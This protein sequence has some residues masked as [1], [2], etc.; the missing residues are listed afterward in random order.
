MPKPWSK[1][2]IAPITS[3]T[4]SAKEQFS[5]WQILSQTLSAIHRKR[6]E[7]TTKGPLDIRYNFMQDDI[8]SERTIS[9]RTIFT[10]VWKFGVWRWRQSRCIGE[11][12][13]G[14]CITIKIILSITLSAE[15][16]FSDQK[17]L[18]QISGAITPAPEEET[19]ECQG[20]RTLFTK[21]GYHHIWKK[22]A[23]EDLDD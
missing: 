19:T 7:K 21:K 20:N 12:Q 17:N 5:G 6:T 3:K 14:F 18:S 13:E 23:D 9:E 15:E 22:F 1:V 4:M 8:I 11:I 2:K 10:I 16:K